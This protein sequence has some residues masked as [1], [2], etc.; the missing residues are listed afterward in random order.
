MRKS[1]IR[2]IGDLGG[3]ALAAG[4]AL[5]KEM[6]SGIASRPFGVL[7]PAAAPTRFV[8]DRVSR[9]VY[10]GVGTSLRGAARGEAC[11]RNRRGLRRVAASLAARSGALA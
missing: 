11:A 2:A 10:A 9:A 1:D 3:E 5:I 7:G 6:H 8:H 4:G